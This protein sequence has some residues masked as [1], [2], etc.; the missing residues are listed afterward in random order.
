LAG[1]QISAALICDCTATSGDSDGEEGGHV[2]CQASHFRVA[3]L[4]NHQQTGCLHGSVFSS[5][6]GMWSYLAELPLTHDILTESS[7]VVGKTLYVP[8]SNSLVLAFDMDQLS[9]TTFK[10]PNCGNVRL[11][12][13]DDG[14]LGLY[15]LM[16]LTVRLWARYGDA[17][18]IRKTVGLSEILRAKS[19]NLWFN[20]ISPVK[21]IGVVDGSDM[22]FLWTE[23]GI[24]MLRMESRT[25]NKVYEA[26]RYMQTIYPYGAFYLPPATRAQRLQLGYL[27]M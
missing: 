27:H 21:I 4:F 3:V 6:T 13:T 5:R 12:K 9:T 26:T 19:P 15:G 16:D 2:P 11:L 1:K 25:L 10:R 7:A 18:L 22:L 24:F 20:Y 17:W 23:I 8:M 14:V